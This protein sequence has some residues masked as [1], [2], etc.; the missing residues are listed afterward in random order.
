MSAQVGEGANE[1]VGGPNSVLGKAFAILSAFDGTT[2]SLRLT[3][4][5]RLTGIP[6]PTVYRLAQELT[7][8]GL[9]DRSG[10]GYRLGLS[11]FELGQRV[12][13]GSLL[14]AASRPVI[15]DLC[16]ATHATI[17]LAIL[18]GAST[19]YVERIAG[20]RGM[21]HSLA[22]AGSCMPVAVTASGRLLLA[23]SPDSDEVLSTQPPV[24]SAAVPDTPWF[25]HELDQIRDRRLAVERGE[26]VEGYKTFA[27]PITDAASR[28]VASLSATVDIDY[29]A[30]EQLTVHLR[31]A[32]RAIG[33]RLTTL[34]M[35]RQAF[36]D[37]P[38]GRRSPPAGGRR[39]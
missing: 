12:S 16:A 35:T 33:R 28:T 23:M 31:I 9:L 27:V 5:S 14:H 22:R 24:V 32:S 13:S 6:K 17:H 7:E 21:H 36:P 34:G 11:L 38:P 37:P 30:E 26:V 19:Y 25:R 20:V 18:D 2:E 39:V 3:Q 1:T 10:T 8:L 4:L 29:D 15:V